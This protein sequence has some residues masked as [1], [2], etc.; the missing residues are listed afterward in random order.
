M[1]RL[2]TLV[3]I[4]VL[5]VA[6]KAGMA[7]A[8]TAGPKITLQPVDKSLLVDSTAKFMVEATGTGTLTYQWQYRKNATSTWAPSGQTGAKTSTLWVK[9]TAGLHG[10]QFRCIVTDGNKQQTVSNTVTL[11]L[12]PRIT[13]QPED[14]N[15]LV[16]STAKLTVEASG[17]GLSYQWQYRKNSSSAWAPS[18]QTG[19]KTSTLWVA[20][21][22]ALHGYQF[23]C[24]VT[25]K[26]K[27]Q[28]ISRVVTLTLKPRITQQP[29]GRKVTAGNTAK[30]TVVA[31][32]KTLSYQWQYRKNASSA[33]ASSAQSG[34]KTA[35]LSVASTAGLDGYQFRCVITDG[36][37][38]KTYS[39][40]AILGVGVAINGTSFPDAEFRSFVSENIDTNHSGSL[41]VSEINAVTNLEL[42]VPAI[43][44]KGIELF[45]E[46]KTLKMFGCTL[47]DEEA[48]EFVCSQ[49]ID[50]SK[51]SKLTELE[52][53]FCHS[54]KKLN[55]SS[56][57][58]LEKLYCSDCHNLETVV[59]GNN[60]KLSYVYFFMCPVQGFDPSL[61]T[62]LKELYGYCMPNESLDLSRNVNL[63]VIEWSD[64]LGSG[65]TLKAI[66]VSK[67]V[68][69]LRL[70]LCDN[71]IAELDI[72]N[73]TKLQYLNV[74]SNELTS[75][76]VSKCP[77][78]EI[79][80]CEYNHLQSLDVSNHKKLSGLNCSTAGMMWWIE[81]SP[82]AT[83][84]ASGCSSLEW[85]DCSYN[86]LTTIKLDGCTSL[87]YLNCSSN[88]LTALKLK[89]NTN[90]QTLNCKYNQLTEIDLSDCVKLTSEKVEAD[91][92]VTIIYAAN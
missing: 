88:N 75:L 31:T 8:A 82:L 4:V 26:N 14:K 52:L 34:N 91:S 5:L 44:F 22:A 43:N 64:Y 73:C 1:K 90:L 51:N 50:L 9:A 11:T 7:N 81:N 15:L 86:S 18:G 77:D 53:T 46:M 24:I 89:G 6:V 60:T 36:N 72:S 63:E 19:A 79:I 35:T 55:L 40:A 28:S 84:D 12:K 33:W 65:D 83:L 56:N 58:K 21:T 32:G 54:L 76:D 42:S 25:D 23:R 38:Q 92:E 37:G 59:F 85:I 13:L 68:N 39:N 61:L 29:T 69:L 2:L 71:A 10:Y 49:T 57:T 80:Y 17:A 47:W 48:G 16:G 67:C 3:G 87:N 78:L 74:W 66:D 45:K 20:T 62:G 30:F 41:S 27:Q 70:Y